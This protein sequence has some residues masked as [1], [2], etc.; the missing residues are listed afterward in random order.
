MDFFTARDRDLAQIAFLENAMEGADAAS[1]ETLRARL[2]IFPEGFLVAWEQGRLVGYIESCLWDRAIPEFQPHPGF[3]AEQHRPA[4]KTLY[5]IFIGV[6][7]EYRRQSVGSQLIEA[8]L[9]ATRPLALQRVHAVSRDQLMPFYQN[10][11]FVAKTTLPDFLHQG[12]YFLMEK[13]L[14]GGV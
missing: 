11:G 7:E 8:L 9:Q 1:V 14:P 10:L 4:A 6:R 5:I 13:P 2:R 3:F 12:N